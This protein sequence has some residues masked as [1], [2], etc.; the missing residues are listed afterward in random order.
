MNKGLNVLS[1]FDGMSCGQLALRKLGIK[2]NGYLASEIKPH[3]IEV[4]QHNFPNTIQLGDVTKIDGKE[5]GHIDLLIGGSPCQDL[6]NAM[7]DRQGLKGEKSKLFF[8]YVRLLKECNPKW[9]LLENVG[10]M[11]EADKEVITNILGVDPIHINSSLVSGQLRSRY[12]WTNVPQQ[13][14]LEDRGIM[15]NDILEYGWSDR[16]KARC[17]LESDSR[18]LTTPVKMFHRYYSTGFNTLIFRSERH[19]KDC[20]AHYEKHFKGL[21]A[22]EI[23]KLL[24]SID[25][26]VYDGVRYL[27]QSELEALQTVPQ[28]YTSCIGRNESASLLG[29]GWTV[30]VIAH[31]LK[32]ICK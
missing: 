31:L 30:D 27:N 22:V 8:E 1:L 19:Y 6:S 25:V 5:L 16:E 12:Y 24:P 9:F 14:T 11:T 29:D 32:G 18:P 23:D 20:K 7:R 4:T 26:S 28:G 17:L 10:S 21:K 13:T 15:L 3:G 2:V